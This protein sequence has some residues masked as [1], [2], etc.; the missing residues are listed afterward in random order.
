[1]EGQHHVRN[2]VIRA[3]VGFAKQV[4]AQA[5]SR[6]RIPYELHDDCLSA[7]HLALV[8][9]AERYDASR[10]T[11][12][13]TFAYPR[14]YGAVLD[15]ARSAGALP[16]NAYRSARTHAGCS[17]MPIP[18]REARK[19]EK[20][21]DIRLAAVLDY[22]AAAALSFRLVSLNNNSQLISPERDPEC[23]LA[24]KEEQEQ[25]Q[26]LLARLSSLERSVITAYY[27]S[28]KSLSDAARSLRISKGWASK[29]QSRALNK[30]KH[31]YLQEYEAGS[32]AG[33]QAAA[34]GNERSYADCRSPR[35]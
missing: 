34:D 1:M 27:I 24:Q 28:G 32:A 33:S 11:S 20:N 14:L 5:I 25:L 9:A 4:A 8:Q 15:Y 19:P 23:L 2:N 22:A 29:L 6:S 30:L 26:G 18:R 7:A 17:P 31:M 12:F 35:F 3:H 13:K 16:R 10:G 21:A